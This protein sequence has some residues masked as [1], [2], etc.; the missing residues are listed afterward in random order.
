MHFRNNSA[1]HSIGIVKYRTIQ[2]CRH[3]LLHLPFFCPAFLQ[4][5]KKKNRGAI[6]ILLLQQFEMFLFFSTF[7]TTSNPIVLPALLPLFTIN[8]FLVVSQGSLRTL[9]MH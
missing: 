8:G 9:S 5:K 2:F 6:F 4:V 7:F 3:G 1:L